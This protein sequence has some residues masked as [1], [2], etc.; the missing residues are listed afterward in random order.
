MVTFQKSVSILENKQ[1]QLLDTVR[2][3]VSDICI[4]QKFLF[5]FPV[6]LMVI[7]VISAVVGTSA[8]VVWIRS[9]LIKKRRNSS[10]TENENTGKNLKL[11]VF[12]KIFQ[13]VP[14][15]NFRIPLL[16]LFFKFSN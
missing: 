3:L 1:N 2:H 8:T 15:H 5:L 13:L 16:L 7:F 12:C 10:L 6:V 11:L 4:T 9:I 14:P